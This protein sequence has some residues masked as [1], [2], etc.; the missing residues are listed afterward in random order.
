MT[1]RPLVVVGLYGGIVQWDM[2]FSGCGIPDFHILD[3]DREGEDDEDRMEWCEYAMSV[4]KIMRS[5][6]ASSDY[7]DKDLFRVAVNRTEEAI[8]EMTPEPAENDND[9]E[10]D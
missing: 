5:R 1:E 7:T 6:E 2:L 3:F 10:D 4:V 9:P 8:I